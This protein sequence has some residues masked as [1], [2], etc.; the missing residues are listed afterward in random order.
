MTPLGQ[1][2][3]EAALPDYEKSMHMILHKKVNEYWWCLWRGASSE[4]DEAPLLWVRQR[5]VAL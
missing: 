5:T 3:V 1:L 2:M 4:M